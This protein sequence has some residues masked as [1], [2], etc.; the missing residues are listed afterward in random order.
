MIDNFII[1][2][3]GKRVRENI[4]PALKL[5]NQDIK[6]KTFS[7]NGRYLDGLVYR[8]TNNLNTFK[9]DGEFRNY[10]ISVPPSNT[11]ECLE[12][13]NKLVDS[14]NINI[15][16]DTPVSKSLKRYKNANN[17][18]VL[19]DIKFI[20][21]I[22]YFK[23]NKIDIK[24]I[25]LNQSGYEYHGI[26]LAKTI[27]DEPVLSSRRIFKNNVDKTFIQF[28]NKKSAEIINPRAYEYGSIQIETSNHGEFFLGNK[29]N[30]DKERFKILEEVY[31]LE[32]SNEIKELLSLNK[33]LKIFFN[34]YV[35]SME[36]MK[37]VGLSRL[38]N[39]FCLS[40]MSFTTITDSYEEQH[41]SNKNNVSLRLK[42]IIKN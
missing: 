4:I 5:L 37:I 40:N 27:I 39:K 10:I 2:G 30:I 19:E 11:L 12:K 26:A 6:Y 13:I 8:E 9:V 25:K 15:F 34:N 20:P 41:I 35:K 36:V 18:C 24:S 42:K 38:I 3:H 1:F 33:N 14:E 31:N 32:Q 16:I 28:S 17:I 29:R 21:W 22:D 23:E 7:K